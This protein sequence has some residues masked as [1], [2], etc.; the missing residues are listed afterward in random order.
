MKT[1][2]ACPFCRY[3]YSCTSSVRRIAVRVLNEERE[4]VQQSL[5]RLE[6]NVFAMFDAV[7]LVENERFRKLR[8]L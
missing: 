2:M 4:R 1:T 3:M 7:D 8:D 5:D 6:A